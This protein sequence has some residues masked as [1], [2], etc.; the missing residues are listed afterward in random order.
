MGKLNNKIIIVTGAGGGIGLGI[1]SAFAKEGANL[2]ITDIAESSLKKSKDILE[3]NF[4]SEILPIVAD[5]SKEDSV[6]EVIEKTIE[7]FGKI[8]VLVN[9][10]QASKAGMLIEDLSKEDFD[11]AINTGLY[12]TFFYMKYSLQYLKKSKGSIINFASAVGFFGNVG[13][14]SYAASKEAIRALSRVAAREWGQYNINVN[15]VCPLAF[16]PRLKQ[17]SE[18]Y[19][20]LFNDTIKDIPLGRYGDPENDIGK[21]CTFLASD[22]AKYISGETISVQGGSGLRP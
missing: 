1:C 15:V 10:A 11:L 7:K 6:K 12:A 14:S 3:N 8:D 9:N 5:G 13:Q 18:E 22:D 19:P 17:W 4:S 2:V 20:D 21:V 16:T